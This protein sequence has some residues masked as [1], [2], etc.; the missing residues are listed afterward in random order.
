[1]L[2]KYTMPHVLPTPT[3]I[4][5]VDMVGVRGLE[6]LGTAT[7]YSAPRM[8]VCLDILG[9]HTAGVEQKTFILAMDLRVV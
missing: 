2:I 4:K 6:T 8:C 3:F 9:A 1:M 5:P 7:S